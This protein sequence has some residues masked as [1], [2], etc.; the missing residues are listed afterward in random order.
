MSVQVP[1]APDTPDPKTIEI[2]LTR[3]YVAVIDAE[4]RDV[5]SRKWHTKLG[6]YTA[7]ACTKIGGKPVLLH[8]LLTGWEYVDHIDGNGLNNRRSNLRDGTGFKNQANTWIRADNNSGFKGV[9]RRKR[10]GKWAAAIRVNGKSVHLGLYGTPEEA[11][12][13]Y[14]QAAIRYFGE[15]ARTNAMLSRETGTR[16]RNIPAVL[17]VRRPAVRRLITHCPKGHEYTPENTYTSPAGDKRCRQCHRENRRVP[18]PPA[19]ARICPS[20]CAC[21]RHRRAS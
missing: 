13:A 5:A 18:N 20:G 1:S 4:D 9:Y 14:D 17:A 2:P 19:N 11:A 6:P 21:G 10:G 16:Q 3:G 12:D 15:Y 7:Y 8:N